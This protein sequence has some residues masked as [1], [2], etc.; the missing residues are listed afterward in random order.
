M[1]GAL[2]SERGTEFFRNHTQME[3]IDR[4]QSGRYLMERGMMSILISFSFDCEI[5]QRRYPMAYR[6]IGQVFQH[7]VFH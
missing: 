7:C 2:S 4:Q 1:T 6:P 5:P 3:D